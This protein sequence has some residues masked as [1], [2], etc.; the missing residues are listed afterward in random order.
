MLSTRI[1]YV[2]VALLLQDIGDDFLDNSDNVVS[3]DLSGNH[4]LKHLPRNVFSRLQ[5]LTSLILADCRLQVLYPEHVNT[6]YESESLSTF[7]GRN[8]PW[9]C[10]QMCEF[11]AW[12][13][14]TDS[15]TNTATM[16]LCSSPESLRNRRVLSLVPDDVCTWDTEDFPPIAAIL[17]WVIVVMATSTCCIIC[18]VKCCLS[19]CHYSSRESDSDTNRS[20]NVQQHT[21]QAYEDTDGTH[22]TTRMRSETILQSDCDVG[23]WNINS[24]EPPLYDVVVENDKICKKRI[25]ERTLSDADSDNDDIPPP[26]YNENVAT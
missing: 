16:G 4:L 21:N 25:Y 11:I 5:N 2:C 8:N 22:V 13:H 9:K 18:V 20:T 19:Y 23:D 26:P 3:I 10:E 17:I 7:D 12:L 1:S 14:T 6:S 24:V 15:F